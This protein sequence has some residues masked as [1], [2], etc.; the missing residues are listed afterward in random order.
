MSLLLEALKR[1]EKAKAEAERRARGAVEAAGADPE[2]TSAQPA[3]HV[4]TRDDLPPISAPL[5]IATDDLGAPE[6]KKPARELSLE[7]AQPAPQPALR[8]PERRDG[9]RAASEAAA[10]D[11]AMAQKVF[12]AKLRE[13]NPRLPFYV[14]LGVLGIAAVGIFVYFWIQLQPPPPLVNP[15]PPRPPGE[16]P[17][18]LAQAK[19]AEPA[20]AAPP[21][22]IPGLPA[23]PAQSAHAVQPAAASAPAVPPA[24]AAQSATPAP[25]KPSAA[26]AAVARADPPAPKPPARAVA[27]PSTE[28]APAADHAALSVRRPEL[29]VH[30]RVESGYAAYHAGDLARARADYEAALR[31]DPANRDALLGLAAVEMRSQRYAE[32]EALYQKLLAANPR[33]PHAQAG[34]LALRAQILDPVLAESRVKT[35]LAADPEAAA[36]HFALGNQYALQARWAEAQQAYFRAWVADPENPDFAYNLAVSLDQLR[37]SALAA[38]YY[39]R[40]LAL[41]ERRAANFPLEAARQRAAQLA[42]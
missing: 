24:P 7:E 38:E 9:A 31:E 12:E 22:E 30:P 36:L 19:P 37:Q 26:P 10:R 18:A 8:S 11:R 6:E 17:T 15:N 25:Q 29:Q 33:D 20:P 32:A 5:E 1:A 41:A 16:L 27:A 42:R 13:P 39:R 3:K 4:T 23:A 34:L 35:L 2:P 40:A 28:R 14:T 21:P